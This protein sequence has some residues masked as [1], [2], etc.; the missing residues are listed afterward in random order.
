MACGAALQF[1]ALSSASL[2]GVCPG[3]PEGQEQPG[4]SQHW[5]GQQEQG[6]DRPLHWALGR[7]QLVPGSPGWPCTSLA[8]ER[9]QRLLAAQALGAGPA[10]A[11]TLGAPG[12]GALSPPAPWPAALAA[13]HTA[14]QKGLQLRFVPFQVSRQQESAST[15]LEQLRQ[16][17]SRQGLAL[18]KV[19]EEKEV[20][21]QEKAALELRLAAVER[22]RQGLSEQLAEARPVKETLARSLFEAQQ[23][24]SQLEIARSHLEMR[25]HTVTQAKDVIQGEVKCL[26]RELEAE[27]SLLRQERENAAQQLL[28]RERQHDDALR[29]RQSDHEAETQRLL[30]D[31]ARARE[32]H[33]SELQE[34]LE[35]W[36]QEKAETEREHE[37]QLVDMEQKVAAVQAQ[38]QEEQTRRENAEREAVLEKEREKNSLLE[39]L[40][41]TQGE[42]TDACQR[43][44]QLRQQMEEQGEKGQQAAAEGE[45][46]SWLSEKRRLSQRLECLQGAVARLELEKT[47]LKQYNAELRRTL[48]QVER[49]RRRLKRCCRG[50]SLPDACALSLSY[51]R[52]VPASRQVALLETQLVQEP[53]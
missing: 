50:R 34:L 22:D 21:V 7:P 5:C 51:Q 4:L 24:V 41:Q 29:L 9:G 39:L 6:S 18:A 14:A 43:V 44:E 2:A 32:G 53:K 46:L 28:R 27:R 37:K 52:K 8:G 36:Q 11:L 1:S 19:S 30:Q 49:E 10:A 20:L 40:R 26:Q 16:E 48:E 3:V 23:R 12:T 31:L 42:L 35:R 45:Q 47:E 15:G 38:R 33:Q 25:L 17:S 13:L